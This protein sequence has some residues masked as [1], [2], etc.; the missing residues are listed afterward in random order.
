MTD[1]DNKPTPERLLKAGDDVEDFVSDDDKLTRRM[2]DGS[3]LNKMLS[4]DTIDGE[5]Y[6]AG[7]KYYKDWYLGGFAA[8]GVVDP[9]KPF[10]DGGDPTAGQATR[11]YHANRFGKAA[12]AIGRVLASVVG[13]AILHEQRIDFLAQRYSKSTDRDRSRADVYQGIRLGLDA[14][15][16]YY[17]GP[18]RSRSHYHR[19]EDS[20]NRH[21]L[22]EEVAA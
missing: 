16:L 20:T 18:R 15:A 12:I 11:I 5:Q 22:R 17:F 10:V 4:R 3:L 8:S 9:S 19:G 14:L 13:D 7:V 6:N 1:I 2:L 21:D